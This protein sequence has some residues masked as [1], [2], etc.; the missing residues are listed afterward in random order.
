MSQQQINFSIISNALSVALCNEYHMLRGERFADHRAQ[1][2]RLIANTFLPTV[3]GE[4]IGDGNCL[5]RAVDLQ[6]T[7]SE[8]NYEIL[9]YLTA[10]ELRRNRHNFVAIPED[11]IAKLIEVVEAPHEWGEFSHLIVLSIA[12]R[13]PISVFD[14]SRQPPIWE[15]I[16]G[17]LNE[18][19]APVQ[20]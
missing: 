14:R 2:H 6:I 4:V 11:D 3:F 9:K 20:V 15:T 18:G 16:R 5:F 10:Q 12:L 8:H 17:Q 1:I 19:C 13:I 7:G